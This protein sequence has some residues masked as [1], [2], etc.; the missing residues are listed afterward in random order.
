MIV[1]TIDHDDAISLCEKQEDH[2]FDRK[3]YE[4]KP[5]KI[6]KIAVA[7][8]NAD[9]GEFVVGI[10]DIKE[11]PSPEDRWNGVSELED[12]NAH[13]QALQEVTPSLPFRFS[14]FAC[15]KMPGYVLHVEIDKSSQVHQANDKKVYIRMSAQSLPLKDTDKILSLTYA[16][17]ASSFEDQVVKGAEIESIVDS[18][19]LKSFL[20]D[21]SPKTDQLEFVVNQHLCDVKTWEPKVS[22]ILLFSN[23]PSAIMPRQCAIK[24]ARYET[25]ED[26]PERDHLKETTAVEG[27]LYEQIHLAADIIAETMSSISIWTTKGLTTVEYPPE[28][29]WEI[30]V[31]AAIHRDYSISDNIHIHIYNNRIEIISPGKFPGYVTADNILDVRYSRNP[32]IVRTLSRYKVPPNQDM[33]EGLNTAFQKMKEWRLQSPQ[34]FEEGNYVKAIIPH[35][36]LATPEEAV[37]AFLEHNDTIKNSQARELTGIKSENT[38]KTIFYKLRDNEIIERVPGL[39]GPSAA[40]RKKI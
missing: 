33:G 10:A 25:K 19:Q 21:Y 8:A 20:K 36:S 37:I 9:G 40:W 38:M 30:L 23:E 32:R 24:I 3:A 2:F 17:G 13:I 12:F 18:S 6:Q 35:T 7:F 15:N 22:G 5:A 16:K 14:F 1:K 29:I 28:A 34:I 27:P 31:N 11:F 26:D 39:E 4:I